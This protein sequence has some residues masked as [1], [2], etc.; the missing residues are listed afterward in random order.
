MVSAT[1][2][3]LPPWLKV[4]LGGGE[5]ALRIRDRCERRGLNTVC[6]EARCPNMGECWD[7]GTATFMVLGPRCTRGCRF[8]G[9]PC[10]RPEAPDPLE[11]DNL[12]LT[13]AE[14]GLGYAVVT[15]VC[16]DDL[17]DGGAGHLAACLRRIKARSPATAL[18]ALVGDF[19]G[20]EDALAAV[21][22]AGP[23]VL[24]HNIETVER[25]GRLAR[26][27]RCGYQRSLGLLKAARRLSPG[28]RTKSSLMLGL[29]ET[30]AEVRAALL[31]L[32]EA[33]VSILTIGQ[34]LR[35]AAAGRH[36]PVR[37]YVA[38]ERFERWGAA[39]RTMGFLRVAAA[40]LARSSYRAA[41]LSVDGKED[42]GA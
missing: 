25:I 14:L 10:G 18:E 6:V 40:P 34:Y 35:P 36:L 37:E 11:P 31:D 9:V 2:T 38:P 17:A 13:I 39:A 22:D 8:C 7:A 33:G 28:V 32:R 15:M 23:A 20:D 12:A 26:D 16:R 24:G 27:A 21:L 5:R 4:R 19:Q 30:D 29:G 3:R 1:T 42:H 41:E